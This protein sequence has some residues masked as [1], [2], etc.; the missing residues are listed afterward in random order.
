MAYHEIEPFGPPAF[1]VY[2]GMT[3]A[4]IY[5]VNRKQGAKPFTPDDFMLRK[6]DVQES[7]PADVFAVF[8]RWAEGVNNANTIDANR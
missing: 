2:A 5:N 1:N 3:T 8:K 4:A 7:D 6:P